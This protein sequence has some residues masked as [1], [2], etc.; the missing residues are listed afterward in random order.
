MWGKNSK[1]SLSSCMESSVHDWG[2]KK[3]LVWGGGFPLVW[4][5]SFTLVFWYYNKNLILIY[6]K[7]SLYAT[8]PCLVNWNNSNSI[9]SML[10]SD[11]IDGFGFGFVYLLGAPVI[12]QSQ[13]SVNMVLPP[14][15]KLDLHGHANN[16]VPNNV[17]V[18]LIVSDGDKVSVMVLLLTLLCQLTIMFFWLGTC[19]CFI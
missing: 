12:H 18:K 5:Y 1:M 15:I 8:L 6:T 7:I 2:R 13:Q 16:M 14:E 4:L 17:S 19:F 3:C 10:I 11:A 9:Q